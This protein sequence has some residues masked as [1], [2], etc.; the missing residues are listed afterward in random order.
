[1]EWKKKILLSFRDYP[2]SKTN[3]ERNDRD[4]YD[5]RQERLSHVERYHWIE[6]SAMRQPLP[7][8][9]NHFSLFFEGKLVEAIPPVK[10]SPEVR[11][12][13]SWS[14]KL[15]QNETFADQAFSESKGKRQILFDL[16]T[17]VLRWINSLAAAKLKLIFSLWLYWSWS[18][19]VSFARLAG[20]RWRF[21]FGERRGSL[22]LSRSHW[23]TI[24][25]RVDLTESNFYLP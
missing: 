1:M 23:S 21:I 18:A 22:P 2:S 4:F 6:W 16:S 15:M 25:S 8:R 17:E 3:L 12:K 11:V 13:R 10:S 14:A 5:T 7:G 9:K 20:L 24:Q 19:K